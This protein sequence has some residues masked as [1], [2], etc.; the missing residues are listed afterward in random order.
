MVTKP[1]AEVEQA[2]LQHLVGGGPMPGTGGDEPE[3]E[4]RLFD[5]GE[6]VCTIVRQT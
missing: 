2:A 6:I 4:G 3:I 5:F 1:F